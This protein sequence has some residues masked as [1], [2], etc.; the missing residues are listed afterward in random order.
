MKVRRPARTA[1]VLRPLRATTKRRRR[2]TLVEAL[3]LV[4]TGHVSCRSRR[5]GRLK[6]LEGLQDAERD[7]ADG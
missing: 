4:A 2:L 7:A 6:R 1:T 3:L 5:R